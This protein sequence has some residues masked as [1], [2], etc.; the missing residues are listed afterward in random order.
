[1]KVAYS[2]I[3]IK[4]GNL[5]VGFNRERRHVRRERIALRRKA[6]LAGTAGRTGRCRRFL[7]NPPV[8]SKAYRWN[9]KKAA[10][11]A[12]LMCAMVPCAA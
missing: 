6:F 1:M 10:F 2:Y 3:Q 8:S 4:F 12:F 7:R 9:I 11:A 5:S